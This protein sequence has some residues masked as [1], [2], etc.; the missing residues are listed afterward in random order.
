M[1]L[2]TKKKQFELIELSKNIFTDIFTG[3]EY[4]VLQRT[5]SFLQL[6]EQ[7]TGQ[8]FDLTHKETFNWELKEN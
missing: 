3:L 8:I 4:I 1:S 5:P 2:K 6:K 7:K